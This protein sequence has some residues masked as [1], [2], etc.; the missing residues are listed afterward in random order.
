MK[1]KLFL[2]LVLVSVV[3]LFSSCAKVPQ[4]EIDAAN[5][6]I[7]DAKSGEADVYVASEFA[8]LNDSMNVANQLVEAKKGKLFAS[9]KVAKAKLTAITAQ[10]AQVKA[11]AATRKEEVK[12]EVTALQGELATLVDQTKKL[13]V[14]APKG[15]EGKA[16]VEAINAEIAAVEATVA[17][18]N[19]LVGQGSFMAALDKAKAAKEK[20]SAIKAE[21]I[22]VLTKAKIKIPADLM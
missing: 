16:A 11:H 15:K 18:V 22:D 14:K 12:A 8:A 19:G 3:V 5:A 6:A 7:A 13:V 2:G 10:A 1:S 4:V 17:E 20:A 21:L 9:M